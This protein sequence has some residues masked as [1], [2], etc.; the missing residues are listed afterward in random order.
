MSV[1][2]PSIRIAVDAANPGQFFACCGLL[3]LADRVWPGAEGWFE[4]AAFAILTSGEAT[5]GEL[6]RGVATAELAQIDPENET[7]SPIVIGRPFNLRL[8]WWEDDRADGK[9]LKVWA[10][11]M[12]GFRIARAMQAMMARE[13]CQASSLLDFAAVV[14]DSDAPDKKVEPF[15][16]DARRGSS[17][18][19]IDIG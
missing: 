8:N 5:V 4:D 3:E 12:R 11:S 7:S 6:V 14:Y 10:G 1:P 17:A 15:Y 2:Q 16:F 13:E 18:L 9:Q 19:P